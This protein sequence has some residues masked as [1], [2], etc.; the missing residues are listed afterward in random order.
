MTHAP[1]GAIDAPDQRP[2]VLEPLLC[3]D[4]Y[5]ASRAVTQA[6][7]PILGELDLT[8]PQYLVLTVL[9]PGEDVPIKYVAETLR[10]DHATLT[11]L[12]RRLETAGLLTRSRSREDERSVEVRLTEHG[13]EVAGRFDDVQCAMGEA[14]GLEVDE[15]RHLQRLLRQL[16]HRLRG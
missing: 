5:A 13:A 14:M 6:Y 12:L 3:F 7:R 16:T 9:R 4:L 2:A 1:V 10:L 15:V 8:Y 11:P